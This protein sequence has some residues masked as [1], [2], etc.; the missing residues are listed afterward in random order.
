MNNLILIADSIFSLPIFI[1]F[2]IFLINALKTRD[3]SG[4]SSGMRRD[5]SGAIKGIMRRKLE[6]NPNIVCGF[7]IHQK[8][9]E[10]APFF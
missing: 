7:P 10:E 3:L 8:A 2:G 1:F 9:R 4:D 6:T 5:G